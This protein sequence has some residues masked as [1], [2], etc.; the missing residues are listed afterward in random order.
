MPR[1]EGLGR[2]AGH[3]VGERSRPAKRLRSPPAFCPTVQGT[4]GGQANPTCAELSRNVPDPSTPLLREWHRRRVT[5]TGGATAAV[6]LARTVLQRAPRIV[7]DS[8]I[9]AG[10]VCIH[11]TPGCPV[12]QRIDLLCHHHAQ[13][14][15]ALEFGEDVG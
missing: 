2:D 3:G 1:A 4:F 7:F 15:R 12:T 9:G 5:L 11:R 10:V 8:I 14:S 6:R 13:R